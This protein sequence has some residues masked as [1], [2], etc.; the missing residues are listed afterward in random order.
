MPAKP[1][2]KAEVNIGI[3][4]HVDHGKTTLVQ[5]LSGEWTDRHSE[6][7]RRGITIKL[8][9]ADVDFLKCPNCP[10]P[11]CYSTPVLSPKNKCQKCGAKMEFL[12][13]VSFV[14]APGHE[15][16]MATTIAGTALMDG[17]ILVIGANESCP[18]PQTRE[19]FE[20]LK[21]SDITNIITVQNKIELI[22]P[23][24]AVEHYRSIKKF[25]GPKL[26][27]KIPIIP[28]SAIHRA[29]LDVLIQKIEEVIP[30]P[31]RDLTVDPLLFIARSFDVNKPGAKPSEIKGGVIAGSISRG[32][33]KVGDELEIQPGIPRQVDGKT[34][35]R[36]ILTRVVSL[37]AGNVGGLNE[38][39]AGGLV[40]I[41]TTLDPSLTKS[42]GLIGNLAGKPGKIP[43]L[44]S[45]LNL[46]FH[47]LDFVVG[48]SEL[49]K[50]DKINV[51]EALMLIVGTIMTSGIVTEVKKNV[52]TVRLK[53]P[54]CADVGQKVALNRLI[55]KRWRLIGYG[56]LKS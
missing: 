12:R 14:D 22:S 32:V 6:E 42:D 49:I 7:I 36:H 31:K 39:D 44:W 40:A 9:Y 45:N 51:K 26:Q 52:I 37:H 21:I 38:V 5:A 34:S 28:V 4:G 17:A 23:E 1:Q 48:T 54:V 15:I 18:Q 24:D 33:I 8:G 47:L 43:P 41:E 29:N 2:R 25:I 55:N 19:H 3:V 30:T 20:T 16:L 46:E 10:E 13:R 56:I 35:Y 50:V 11:E 53:K 27:D